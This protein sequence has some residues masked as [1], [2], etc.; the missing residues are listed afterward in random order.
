MTDPPS[1]QRGFKRLNQSNG[2]RVDVLIFPPTPLLTCIVVKLLVICALKGAQPVYDKVHHTNITVVAPLHTNKQSLCNHRSNSDEWERELN[3]PD[4]SLISNCEDEQLSQ[5]R[6][7]SLQKWLLKMDV[8]VR[9][10][11]LCRRWLTSSVSFIVILWKSSWILSQLIPATCISCV[12]G[13]CIGT[14]SQIKSRSSSSVLFLGPVPRSC[15]SVL[16]LSPVPQSCSSVLFLGHGK[17][18]VDVQLGGRILFKSWCSAVLPSETRTQSLKGS[19]DAQN[20]C[21][22]CFCLGGLWREM[23]PWSRAF[24]A[25][26]P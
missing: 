23:A 26:I 22:A 19:H 2:G 3:H 17:N 11:P 6:K 5:S 18:T 25:G 16:F 13:P 21:P 12:A 20:V 8:R 9:L 10:K 4:W 15:S 24:K 7:P 14:A 1:G